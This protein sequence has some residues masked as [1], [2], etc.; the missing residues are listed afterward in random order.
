MVILLRSPVA[1]AALTMRRALSRI[2]FWWTWYEDQWFWL[3]W[4]GSRFRY[5]AAWMDRHLAM[6]AHARI[7]SPTEIRMAAA[8]TRSGRVRTD[9]AY[10]LA[11]LV[12]LKLHVP[13]IYK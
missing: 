4:V 10:T 11:L 13:F 9:F 7:L 1:A 12:S 3:W 5:T 8:I 2:W 6:P